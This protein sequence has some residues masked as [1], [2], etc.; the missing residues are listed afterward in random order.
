M[1]VDLDV[2]V[3][4]WINI[5][6]NCS[7]QD[8]ARVAQ[9]STTMCSIV[10]TMY[11]WNLVEKSWKY[12]ALD[13]AFNVNKNNI[14]PGA[15]NVI[16]KNM[17][18][19]YYNGWHPCIY[20][21]N[22]NTSQLQFGYIENNYIH[23]I[24]WN[25]NN[26]NDSFIIELNDNVIQVWC[27]N[28][29]KYKCTKTIFVNSTFETGTLTFID[30]IIYIVCDEYEFGVK[31]FKLK[32]ISIG[33]DVNNNTSINL[34]DKHAMLTSLVWTQIIGV[35][36]QHH[37]HNNNHF[38]WKA[39]VKLSICPTQTVVNLFLMTI[40]FFI[41]M[42]QLVIAYIILNTSNIVGLKMKWCTNVIVMY[43]TKTKFYFTMITLHTFSYQVL[44]K[45]IKVICDK[46]K[47]FCIIIESKMSLHV[48][49]A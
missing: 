25:M 42:T 21:L 30:D 9:T 28:G 34:I 40:L 37:H 22:M 4:M 13:M 12:P 15:D 14:I 8:L 29:K 41:I 10:D 18:N 31:R 6:K 39:C 38:P 49:I 7:E 48:I 27:N 24:V 44:V 23:S 33:D 47:I 46:A 36:F 1:N 35:I 16:S 17:V 45:I 5:L 2:P 20:I 43:W 19:I 32:T 26:K 11:E 3:E